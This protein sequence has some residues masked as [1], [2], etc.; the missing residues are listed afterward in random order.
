M[1]Q[2]IGSAVETSRRRMSRDGIRTIARRD[3]SR[4][5]LHDQ[6]RV[7][8]E[9]MSYGCVH[10]RAIEPL[11]QQVAE[12]V[13]PEITIYRVNIPVEEELAEEYDISGTPTFI[14][15]LNGS[16]VGRVEGPPPTFSSVLRTVSDP[17][18][19]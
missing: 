16:V 15:F 2:E 3:F 12:A 9:F 6:G 17:F 1:N 10:C 18:Q 13:R 11:L 19:N 5:V 7:A 8:V 4:L 14:M